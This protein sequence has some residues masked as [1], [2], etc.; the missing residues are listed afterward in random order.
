MRTISF[1][2]KAFE[3][4]NIWAKE[5]PNIYDRIVRIITETARQPFEGIGKP[6]PLKNKLKGFWSRKINDEHRL[7]YEVRTNELVIISCKYHY[8]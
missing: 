6:E 2:P 8:E 4:F 3:E 5:K 1:H 7:V